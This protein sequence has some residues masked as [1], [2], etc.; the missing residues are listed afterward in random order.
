MPIAYRRRGAWGGGAPEP[1]WATA[2]AG[3]GGAPPEPPWATAALGPGVAHLVISLWSCPLLQ[4]NDYS[5]PCILFPRILY[6]LYPL[7]S[8]FPLHPRLFSSSEIVR[9][10]NSA[11]SD[12]FT[13]RLLPSQGLTNWNT[14]FK[15]CLLP[16]GVKSGIMSRGSG[17]G[18]NC[19]CLL[20]PAPA[21]APA[22]EPASAPAPDIRE[23]QRIS[24][25]VAYPVTENCISINFSLQRTDSKRAKRW[26]RRSHSW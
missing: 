7:P 24:R 12:Q 2:A 11:S 10:R 19:N 18:C 22:P 23:Q 4:I 14:P 13:L 16:H 15:I 17:Q 9:P 25:L 1:Q 8:S 21:P 3:P 20:A 6:S 26:R 5:A